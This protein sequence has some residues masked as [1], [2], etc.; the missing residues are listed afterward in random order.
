MKT[1]NISRRGL[2]R[3]VSTTALGFATLKSAFE[4]PLTAAE[5]VGFGP[6]IPDPKGVLDLPRGFK[7]H[8]FS[9]TGDVMHDGFK[10][11]GLHDGMAAFPGP[12]GGAILVRN[13]ENR[14]IEPG[15]TG[16]PFHAADYAGMDKSKIFD[17]GTTNPASGGTTNLLYDTRRKRLVSHHLSLVG[18]IRNCAGGLTPWNS[19]LTCEETNSKAGESVGGTILAH[20]HG[21]IFDVP[22]TA[23]IGLTTPVPLKAMGRFSHEAVSIDPAT[24]IV[25]ETEDRGDSCLYRFIPDIPGHSCPKQQLR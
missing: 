22:A 24:G 13:H 25:Y 17:I 1:T 21:W 8:A 14:V 3:S 10:V 12:D 20:N 6:L 16:S 23:A 2:F 5:G 7:Y 4:R 15:G 19:W 9:V 18:T 11:P